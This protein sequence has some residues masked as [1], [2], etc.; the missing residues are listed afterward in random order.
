VVHSSKVS[1]MEDFAAWTT[2]VTTGTLTSPLT[3]V[4][5]PFVGYY[6]GR[7]IHRK[8]VV[9]KVKERL[10]RDGDIRS[11]LQYVNPPSL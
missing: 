8:T 5:A 2:G 10:E 3:L 9:N 11:V 1:V 7:A 6:A 4:F